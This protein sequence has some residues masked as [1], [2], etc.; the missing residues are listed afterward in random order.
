MSKNKVNSILLN[1]NKETKEIKDV[2]EEIIGPIDWG[3]KNHFEY[4][5]HDHSPYDEENV[6]CFG[7]GKLAGSNLPGSHRLIFSF[8]S[9]LWRGFFFSS[10][11]GAAYT[12]KG[13]GADFVTIE[14]RSDTPKIIVLKGDEENNDS[15]I[16]VAYHEVPEDRLTEIYKDYHGNEGVYGLTEY[17]IDNFS[18][19]FDGDYRSI[20][21]GPA[22]MNSNM[23]GIFSAAI[24]NDE[25]LV[26]SE[27][28]AGRGGGG[29][30]MYQTHGVIG[31]VFGGIVEREFPNMDLS[32]PSK[33]GDLLDDYFGESYHNV[34]Q[35]KTIK[36]R[37]NED[38]G[39]G[40][41]FGNNYPALGELTPIF[42]WRMPH[43]SLEDRIDVHEKIMDKYWK[44]FNEEAIDPRNWANCGEPCPAACK[45]YRKGQHVDYEP[46][47]A[48]GPLS[49]SYDI[50]K[51]D[52]SVHM[53]DAMGFDAI[54]F[55]SLSAWIFELI[56]EGLLD[57][58][59][60]GLSEDPVFELEGF[61]FEEDSET[62]AN[63]VAELAKNIAFAENE[64]CEMLGRGK[65]KAAQE[66][67]EIFSDRLDKDL[68]F[69][70]DSYKDYAVYVPFGEKG[71]I[72][73]T[74]YWAIGNFVPIP[75][76]GKYCTFYQFGVFYDPDILAEKC[77]GQAI[78]EMYSEN[79]GM[80][81][82]HRKWATGV[83]PMLLD[84]SWGIDVGDDHNKEIFQNIVEYDKKAGMKPSFWDSERVIDLVSYGADEFGNDKWRDKFEEDKEGTAREFWESFLEAYEEDLGV[85]WNL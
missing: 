28:W 75:I 32:D 30:V 66:F 41:T 25:M 84:E 50:Y 36:Y 19:Q 64:I 80:C 18:S 60:V 3:L 20:V 7:M 68:K 38:R 39:T 10:M 78:S 74:M 27:D 51:S 5:S 22:A 76:Q 62:N 12:F 49:G 2:D 42:N 72:S 29:T 13:V 82:F 34:I 59:E 57:S 15:N 40:G 67:D 73:P 83:I 8:R 61:D 45:K 6:L 69:D 26:G 17:I 77:Y 55:G 54:D 85:D 37:Y 24:G 33:V 14:G 58:E 23:A 53:I 81:R 9:P 11:G 43:I 16:E 31:I 56:S 21:V 4:E 70:Y 44:P 1:A 47:E 35:D 65:R 46:Y 48:G 71:E 52:V 79:V 63:L